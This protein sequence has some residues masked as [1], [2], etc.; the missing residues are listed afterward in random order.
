MFPLSSAQSERVAV[1]VVASIA[2]LCGGV[3]VQGGAAAAVSRA[4]AASE[5]CD[6]GEATDGNV[7]MPK[8]C[9]K[10]SLAGQIL[11]HTWCACAGGEQ[12]NTWKRR[13]SDQSA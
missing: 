11:D 6:R 2:D 3:V 9:R 13:P 12:Q 7:V 5:V 10:R 8:D 4:T 1:G